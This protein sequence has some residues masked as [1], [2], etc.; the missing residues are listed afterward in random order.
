MLQ[1]PKKNGTAHS[2]VKQLYDFATKSPEE[3]FR[4]LNTDKDGLSQEEVERKLEIYGRNEL[5]HEKPPRWY[6]QLTKAF[7]NPFTGILVFLAIVSYLTDVLFIAPEYRDWSTIIIIFVIILIS[8]FFCISFKNIAQALKRKKLKAMIHTTA[9]VKRKGTDVK[10]IN[11]EEIVPGGYCIFSCWRYDT[12][13]FK[14][15][16]IK[17]SF[18]KSGHFNW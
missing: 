10:E 12:C 9:A 7:I 15:H 8:G 18:C 3:L 4:Q 17:R 6:I 14:N 13:R 11:I 2:I 16:F 1:I 5:A